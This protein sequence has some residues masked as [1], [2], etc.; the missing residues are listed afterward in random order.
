MLREW[1]TQWPVLALTWWG[2]GSKGPA[3]RAPVR[4][5]PGAHKEELSTFWL[6]LVHW[7]QSHFPPMYFC[8]VE[9]VPAELV[10][11]T[12]R[13][14]EERDTEK[15]G[16]GSHSDLKLEFCHTDINILLWWALIK[17]SLC[18]ETS[19]QLSSSTWS[20]KFWRWARALTPLPRAPTMPVT[21]MNCTW[22]WQQSKFLEKPI[23]NTHHA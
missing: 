5:L 12:S 14:G 2:W 10:K 3:G 16:V 19:P 15:R 22:P 13:R 20:C 21:M 9:A 4:V 18:R 17:L 23:W 6:S 1:R 7:G 11:H 8:C